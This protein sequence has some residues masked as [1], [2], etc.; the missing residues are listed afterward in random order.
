MTYLLYVLAAFY[1]T[2]WLFILVGSVLADVR[3]GTGVGP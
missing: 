1:I 3:V 2:G